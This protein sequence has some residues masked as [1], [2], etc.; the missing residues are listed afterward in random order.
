MKILNRSRISAMMNMAMLSAL[1]GGYD[2]DA[3]Y[4]EIDW[5]Y[6]QSEYRL[7]QQK[8]SNL[9]RREREWVVS[10][11]ENKIRKEWE[12]TKQPDYKRE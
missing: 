8:K 4:I 12:E 1:T 9:S 3:N 10:K 6:I 7:I 11:W 2:K 5:D